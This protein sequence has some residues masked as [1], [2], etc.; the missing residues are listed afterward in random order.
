MDCFF[1]LD[2]DLVL[3][4]AI[5]GFSE[6][7]ENVAFL[8]NIILDDRVPAN[9]LNFLLRSLKYLGSLL[10]KSDTLKE[11]SNSDSSIE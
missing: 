7:K 3:A 8:R 6:L 1:A 4:E 9:E 2:T 10:E 5:E 11:D